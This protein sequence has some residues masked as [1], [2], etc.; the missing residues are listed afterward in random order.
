MTGGAAGPVASDPVHHHVCK[1]APDAQNQRGPEGIGR[2]RHLAGKVVAAHA[3]LLKASSCRA[4]GKHCI[5]TAHARAACFC[6]AGCGSPWCC[7]QQ[8]VGAC[9]GL[10]VARSMRAPALHIHP[11]RLLQ[12]A[13]PPQP[14]VFGGGLGTMALP[15]Q[16]PACVRCLAAGQRALPPAR[17]LHTHCTP[18]AQ[19]THARHGTHTCPRRTTACRRP[20]CSLACLVGCLRRAP[21][22][23]GLACW[24]LREHSRW[25]RRQSQCTAPLGRWASSG[26]RPS[27]PTWSRRD[28]AA[29]GGCRP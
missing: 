24:A 27:R 28:G 11:H 6:F 19:N 14:D 1:P 29:A 23:W 4:A 22:G 8:M 18:D 5:R 20:C 25:P 7:P 10:P 16:V 15:T 21:C 26:G 2:L 13:L 17:A 9:P 12:P 3:R